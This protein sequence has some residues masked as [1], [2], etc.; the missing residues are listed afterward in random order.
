[1]TDPDPRLPALRALLADVERAARRHDNV[2][3]LGQIPLTFEF[4][5]STTT[6]TQGGAA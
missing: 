2:F 4:V 6:S 3:D 5:F 1:M